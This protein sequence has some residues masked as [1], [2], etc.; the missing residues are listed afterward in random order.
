MLVMKMN[1]IVD[2]VGWSFLTGGMHVIQMIAMFPACT[3]PP[4]AEKALLLTNMSEWDQALDTAQRIIDIDPNHID[5]LKVSGNRT[6][7]QRKYQ[8][9]SPIFHFHV[10]CE[11]D[12]CD[13]RV[14][15]RVS[16]A[17]LCEEAGGLPGGAAAV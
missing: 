2:W 1:V 7:N 14:Y 16:A 13:P 9:L 11:A 6:P 3:T 8:L 4:L 5:A 17:G 12:H 15:A 10:F